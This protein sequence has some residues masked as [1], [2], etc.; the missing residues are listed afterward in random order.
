MRKTRGDS[1]LLS[2]PE[3]VRQAILKLDTEQGMTLEEIKDQLAVPLNEG[4]F[5]LEA[6]VGTI[7]VFLS[8]QKALNLRSRLQRRAA[9]A[10]QIE[11]AIDDDDRSRID[12][13]IMDGLREIIFDNVASGEITAKDAKALVGL[14]LKAKEQKMDERKL[15]LLEQKAA[16]YDEAQKVAEDDG[17]TPEQRLAKIREGLKV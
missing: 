8:R 10:A 9:Q 2:Q 17:L 12:Q 4:G 6:S 11:G 14:I 3:G 7:S 16:A 5:E 1:I 15:V 13:G